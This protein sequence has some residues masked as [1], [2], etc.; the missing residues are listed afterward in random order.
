MMRRMA[1]D[2]VEDVM[3]QFAVDGTVTDAAD[4]GALVG[5]LRELGA[6]TEEIV[7]AARLESLGPLALDLAIRPDGPCIPLEE[8]ASSSNLDVGL[9]RDLWVAL[10]L[11]ESP[12]MPFPVPPDLADAL[13]MLAMLVDVFGEESVLGFA[14]VIGSSSERIADA[15][16][17]A[18][19]VGVEVPQR[20]GGMP[21]RDVV[22]EYA[23]MAQGLLPSLWDAVGAVF[24]RHLVLVSYEGFEIE[25][26][27]D[28]VTLQRAIGFID[29]VGS[30]ETLRTQSVR[31]M[32]E[33]VNRFERLVGDRVTT[34]GGRLVKL[35][36]DEA[37]FAFADQHAACTCALELIDESP[38]PVR[39]GV[40]FGEVVAMHGDY[41]GPTV[42]LAAR[43]VGV[44]AESTLLVSQTVRDGLAGMLSFEPRDTGVLR[45]FDE[46]ST[47]Y[48]VSRS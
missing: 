9:V 3:A 24:R 14:R 32:A 43:L 4:V 44:A 15:L 46:V 33:S 20:A 37:M 2:P 45:G 8:F 39:V 23:T 21:Y 31:E 30:T 28:G 47:A 41:F 40:A 36:G 26:S 18:A 19:R 48:V 13:R 27:Q 35:I 11:P 10:G 1:H 25:K 38:A 34:S 42:N 6:T 29:L 17:S 16:A 7:A 5:Y 12:P 22:R